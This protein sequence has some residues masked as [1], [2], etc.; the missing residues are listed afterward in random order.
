MR[1]INMKNN[2]KKKIFIISCILLIIIIITGTY[3]YFAAQATRENAVNGETAIASFGLSI[4]KVT[5]A[6]VIKSGIIPMDDEYAPFAAKRLC[7]D[8]NDYA[9]CQIYRISLTNTGNNS[10]YLDGYLNLEMINDDEMRFLKLYY[11]GD[12][13]CTNEN[14]GSSV[15]NCTDSY[16]ICQNNLEQ[17]ISENIKTGIAIDNDDSFSREEDIDSLLTENEF[18]EA[19]KTKSLYVMVWIHNLNEEQ[20]DLQGVQNAFHG[21]VTFL[22]SAGNEVTAIFDD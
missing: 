22:S 19:G 8:N 15:E 6:D 16:E 4:E 9:V 14:C 10:L 2:N 12:N 21:K 18:L 1:A 17:F 7:Y 13:Y 20:D 5:N 11:D 3:A